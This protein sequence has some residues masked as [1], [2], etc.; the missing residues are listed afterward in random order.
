[1][2]AK[3]SSIEEK[4][5]DIT[6][7]CIC[8]EIYDD[9]RVLPCIHTFCLKCIQL[10]G[11]EKK[12]GE[13]MPC[14]I[15]RTEFIIPTA[16]FVGL[17]KNFFMTKLVEMAMLQKPE[18][19]ETLCD[20]CKENND[21]EPVSQ[22]AT[23]T[24]YC[25]DCRDH[26]CDRCFR[27]HKRHKLSR[28][29]Q[30]IAF[31]SGALQQE[32]IRRFRPSKCEQH[33]KEQLKLYCLPCKAV[34]CIM[35]YVEGHGTHQCNDIEKVAE[36]FRN[37]IG[38]DLDEIEMFLNVCLTEKQEV[39]RYRIEVVTEIEQTQAA[40]I[41]RGQTLKEL[42]DNHTDELLKELALI[43][44]SKLKEMEAKNEELTRQQTIL[45]SFKIY[46]LQMKSKGSSSDICRVIKELQD[47]TE[48]LRREVTTKKDMQSEQKQMHIFFEPTNLEVFSKTSNVVGALNGKES[49]QE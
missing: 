22:I 47:R 28:D 48:I 46:C 36:D 45:D 26:L 49:S 44:Q 23:A 35:C 12:P 18:I 27:D 32:D 13:E 25:T 33:V 37:D 10:T 8:A 42:I 30:V 11:K 15:C 6:E 14:P 5:G 9:P 7:C 40:V 41:F 17:K 3:E 38:K 43:K 24:M 19:R 39:E 31:G 1:M 21:E 34:L 20:V 2:T 16:G 29:H 4:L